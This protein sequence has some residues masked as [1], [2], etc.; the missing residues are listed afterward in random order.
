MDPELFKRAAPLGVGGILAAVMFF[1]Y[2]QDQK[3]NTERWRGQTQMLLQVV[4]QNTAAI[5]ALTATLTARL[6]RYEADR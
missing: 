2:R 4:Q 3:D 6:A 1:F 5:T